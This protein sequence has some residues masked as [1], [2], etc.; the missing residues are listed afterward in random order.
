MKTAVVIQMLQMSYNIKDVL[1]FEIV[2]CCIKHIAVFITCIA[3]APTT[4]SHV[5]FK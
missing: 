4:I 1:V 3:T 2:F 5:H